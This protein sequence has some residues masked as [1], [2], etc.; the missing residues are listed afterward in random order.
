[1][2]EEEYQEFQH[3]AI[4]ALMALNEVADRDF[5]LNKWPHWDYELEEGTLTFSEGG[6]PKVVADIQLVGSSSTAL[7]TWMWAW[8][9]NDV[10]PDVVKGMGIV[11]EF[12]IAESIPS[13]TEKL[14]PDDEYLGWAQ[15]AVAARVLGAKGGYRCP[16]KD[17]FLYM[18]YTDIRHAPGDGGGITRDEQERVS[19]QCDEHGTAWATY[20]CQHLTAEPKQEWFSNEPNLENRW[21]DAWC[22]ICDRIF[23]EQGEWNRENEGRA[24][25]KLL[26]HHCYERFRKQA[27][28]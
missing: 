28:V 11:R 7:G 22:A 8:G 5:S 23:E 18:V 14:I 6:V 19:V 21:P 15:T 10:P 16:S 27:I 13:L 17:G 1:M 3:S 2:T 25:I 20:V 24:P 12:G 4:H 9:Y 26:C